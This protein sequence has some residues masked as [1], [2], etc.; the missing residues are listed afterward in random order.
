MAKQTNN[1]NRDVR[2][3]SE[4][5]TEPLNSGTPMGVSEI[6]DNLVKQGTADA[7]NSANNGNCI[8]NSINNLLNTKMYNHSISTVQTDD[9]SA[10]TI[11][12]QNSNAV[13]YSTFPDIHPE[14][15]VEIFNDVL[16]DETPG[17]LGHRGFNASEFSIEEGGAYLEVCLTTDDAGILKIENADNAEEVLNITAQLPE[18]EWTHLDDANYWQRVEYK[19]LPEGNYRIIHHLY[20]N[21]DYGTTNNRALYRFKI[22]KLSAS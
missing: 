4:N 16:V 15:W 8:A 7:S 12:N 6:D 10:V 20:N 14:A 19:Y 2:V 11:V 5:Y 17:T 13:D 22:K 3:G 1:Y 21:P 18:G 9:A